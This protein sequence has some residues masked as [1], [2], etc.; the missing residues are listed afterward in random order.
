MKRK[1]KAFSFRFLL[2]ICWVVFS[3]SLESYSLT[4][5]SEKFSGRSI[6]NLRS[7][8]TNQKAEK[9]ELS[10]LQGKKHLIAMIYTKCT[11]T[12]PLIVQDLKSVLDGLKPK[13]REN[14]K[15]D[16]FSFDPE[17]ETQQSLIEFT[18]KHKIESPLWS[19]YY[20]NKGAVSELAAALDVQYKKL[21][22]GVYMHSNIL[23][24]IDESGEVIAKQIGLGQSEA[25]LKEVNS[26][27]LIVP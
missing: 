4:Q 12:C 10:S 18:K 22:S 5:A 26:K 14:L 2:L 9:V 7:T 1:E 8:W 3:F 24:L 25:F 23:F 6:F 20:S 21:D 19:V 27:L 16:L 13:Q 17:F 11:A 15:I